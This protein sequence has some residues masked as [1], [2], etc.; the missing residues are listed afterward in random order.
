MSRIL[1]TARATIEA[2]MASLGALLGRLG[3]N[4]E[5]S[6]QRILACEGKVIFT[7]MGKAG[8]I[9]KKLAA[10]FAS[11]GTPAFFVHPAEG[12][13]GDSGM[14]ESR[15]LVIALS[16]SGETGELLGFL[17]IVKQVGAPIIAM[18]GR[19]ES[20]LAKA[21]VATLDVGVESEADPNNLAPTSSA[22][23]ALAM[24]DALAMAVMVERGFTK[25]DFA[26]FHPGG[27][28]GA[29]LQ[30]VKKER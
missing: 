19:V 22:I 13:H 28:L 21:S 9:G 10:T 25:E 29:Q 7:G 8:H 20:S 23:A 11:T 3:P 24:G 18:T 30:S 4:F 1:E 5:Q 17:S 12:L 27:A 2:E 6:V 16:N 26:R 14:V 15:D